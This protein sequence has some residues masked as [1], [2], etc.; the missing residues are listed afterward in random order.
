MCPLDRSPLTYGDY[1]RDKAMERK[2]GALQIVCPN[3]CNWNGPLS[4][5]QQHLVTCP[6]E[7][8][9]CSLGCNAKF[10][11]KE[12]EYHKTSSCPKRKVNCNHCSKEVISQDLEDHFVVCSKF[13]IN[14]KNSCEEKLIRENENQHYLQC[15]LQIVKCPF[16][17]SGCHITLP[18]HKME[19]HLQVANNTHLLLLQ[20]EIIKIN[21]GFQDFSHLVLVH[22]QE[23]QEAIKQL[24]N[25]KQVSRLQL[26][27]GDSYRG[28]G[29]YIIDQKNV[30]CLI[31]SSNGWII[32][33][34]D[35]KTGCLWY[36]KEEKPSYDGKWEPKGTL[37]DWNKPTKTIV[38]KWNWN[39][40][41]NLVT[42][43][44]TVHSDVSI[45]VD[46][47][48]NTLTYKNKKGSFE[49]IK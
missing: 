1:F 37:M 11:R 16:E 24:L 36:D 13:P 49:I 38:D 18:R 5:I 45:I 44:N 27:Y 48:A 39:L 14:C 15:P 10:I 3:K 30:G 31:L 34:M 40:Q 46:L 41:Q 17:P 23:Q 20:Q 25:A 4:S 21:N 26:L 19:N 28:K 8:I 6:L 22:I 29:L 12:E 7:Q 33:S 47:T 9:T 35:G 2:M 32:C 42:I 43:S